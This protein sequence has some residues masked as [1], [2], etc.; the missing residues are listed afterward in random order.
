MKDIGQ[1]LM[2]MNMGVRK[3]KVLSILEASAECIDYIHTQE[4]SLKFDAIQA[5]LKSNSDFTLDII[6]DGAWNRCR[7]ARQIF[8]SANDAHSG[9]TITSITLDKKIENCTSKALDKIGA[10]KMCDEIQEHSVAIGNWCIDGDNHV[11]SGLRPKLRP[12]INMSVQGALAGDP[13]HKMKNVN[14]DGAILFGGTVKVSVA[15]PL[16]VQDLTAKGVLHAAAQLD[17][18]ILKENG[19]PKSA[20]ELKPQIDAWMKNSGSLYIVFS[21]KLS[22]NITNPNALDS[23]A[24]VQRLNKFKLEK[25]KTE[26]DTDDISD[27]SRTPEL[28]PNTIHLQENMIQTKKLETLKK[29]EVDTVCKP[30]LKLKILR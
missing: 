1:S 23:E 18:N 3:T 8:S 14:K 30:G 9:D 29:R 20:K 28:L 6:S 22:F 19:I 2:E 24:L 10:T 26:K 21:D 7:N 25:L 13:F 12:E 27:F 11:S 15:A 5:A 4:K 16:T 17:I